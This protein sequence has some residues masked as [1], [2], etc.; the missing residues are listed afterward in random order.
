MTREPKYIGELRRAG[1]CSD[2]IQWGIAGKYKTLAAAWKAYRIPSDMFWLIGRNDEPNG[3]PYHIKIVRASCEISRLSLKNATKGDDRPRLAIEAGERFA[4]N[5]T[6][7]NRSVAW[8][9]ACKIIRRHFPT[10]TRIGGKK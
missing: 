7:E 10:P 8:S 3:S 5:P 4:E 1:A 9:A 6:K 2:A